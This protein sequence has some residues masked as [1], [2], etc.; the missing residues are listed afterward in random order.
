MNKESDTVN[1]PKVISFINMKGGVGKT[2]L[3]KEISYHLASVL[4]KK[5]LL[6]DIDPQANLTQ[7]YFRKYRMKQENSIQTNSEEQNYEL[8][9]ASI[10]N[11]FQ[12]S[13]G[14]QPSREKV[15]VDF[16]DSNISI[17]PGNLSTIFMSTNTDSGSMNQSLYNYLY[18]NEEFNT[19]DFD[20][21]FIDCPPTYSEYTIAAILASQYY[22]IPVKPDAYS[23]LGIQMLDKVIKDI[24][25]KNLLYFQNKPILNL[26]VIFTEIPFYP[27]AGQKKTLEEIKNSRY[28]SNTHFFDSTFLKNN[29]FFKK[30][31]YFVDDKKSERSRENLFAITEE[32]ISRLESF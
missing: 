2:T 4:N 11:V 27:L 21:I 8:Q 14:I 19:T 20:Y 29:G 6:I 30:V 1:K 17:I 3:C 25:H 23:V 10:N 22:I 16:P 31:D 15:I 32:F 18:L 26:G 24:T 12:A 28:L 5:V 9:T 7:S 13:S